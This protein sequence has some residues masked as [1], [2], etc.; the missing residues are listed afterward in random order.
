MKKNE[1]V[2]KILL[3]IGFEEI[4]GYE[5]HKDLLLHGSKISQSRTYS[6]LSDMVTEGL[7]VVR[8]E[9]ST[10]GPK[11]KIFSLSETGLEKRNHQLMDSVNS[12]HRFYM[13]YLG[14][15]PQESNFFDRIWSTLKVTTPEDARVGI[16]VGHITQQL[17]Y[18]LSLFHNHFSNRHHYLLKNPD[19]ELEE[20]G[21][22]W[23]IMDGIY[24]NIPL[25]DEHLDLLVTFGFHR[26]YANPAVVLE[27]YRMLKKNGTLAVITSSIQTSEPKTPMSLAS[28]IEFHQHQNH[29]DHEDWT[30]F[31][32][33]I[34]NHSSKIDVIDMAEICL[35]QA[36]K[37]M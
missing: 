24:D 18:L 9:H 27:W 34:S 25:K 37:E 19:I 17:R 12:V 36:S 1:L 11:R 15:Q 14:Q 32:K 33:L 21:K 6:I 13:E 28:F 20:I 10:H 5:L 35:L 4:H 16:L 23:L 26:N 31:K 2:D 8:W 3:T 22:G 30:V 7:L 29:G